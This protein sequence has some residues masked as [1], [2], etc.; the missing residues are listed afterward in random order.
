MRAAGWTIRLRARLHDERGLSLVEVMAAGMILAIGSFAVAATLNTGLKTS[1]L[2]R[3]R[4]AAKAVAEQQMELARSL[5]YD[6]VG[7][8][9]AAGTIPHEDDT[10]NPDYWVDEDDQTYDADGAGTAVGYEVLVTG[11][12]EPSLAHYQAPVTKGGTTYTVYLYVTWVDSPLDGSGGSDAADGNQDGISDA[13]GHDQKRVTVVAVWASILNASTSTLSMSS[14]FSDGTIPYHTQDTS[15]NQPPS[16]LCPTATNTDLTA[17]FTAQ[18]SDVDGTIDQID[19]D[20]NGDGTYEVIDGGANRSHT[21]SS[22]G[23]YTVVNRVFDDDGASATNTALNCQVTVTDPPPPPPDSTPPTGTIVVNSGDSYTT[24]LQVTLTLSADDGSGSGVSQMQFSD[25][26]TNFGAAQ[27][28]TTSALYTLPGGEGTKT[29]YVKFIDGAGNVSSAYSDT[30]IY[31]VSAP[32]AP[33]GLTVTR[34]ANNRS[35]VLQW[36]APVPSPS[37]LAGYQVWRRATTAATYS[38]I[39]CQYNYGVPTKCLDPSMDSQ[40]NYEYYVV[41]VDLAGNQS[42]QSNHVTV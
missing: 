24:Q 12:A 16:V 21:Y 40:T 33:T 39:A 2:S 19:W 5:N 13:S 17:N 22:A 32:G 7:L 38:Q 3:Q 25:D 31:D 11:V 26:G 4:L 1:G 41:S 29:V 9:D 18:A 30:I 27:S 37:D 10:S 8:S 35:A 23:T 20:F 15:V 36:N 14:L 34:A 28:Y 42:A 6:H